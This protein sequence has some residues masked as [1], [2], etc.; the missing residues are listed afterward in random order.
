MTRWKSDLSDKIKQE[1]FQAVTMLVLVY[2]YTIWNN[3]TQG[4][5]AK[6]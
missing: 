2:G 3:K 5:K 1:F 6:G 4:K